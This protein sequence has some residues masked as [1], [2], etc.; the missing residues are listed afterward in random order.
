MKRLGI[1]RLIC[2]TGAMAGGDTPNWTR[3]VLRFVRRYRRKFPS[4][5]AD[6]DTQERIVRESGLDW[7]LV[8]PFRISGE[9]RKDRV[10]VAPG[11]RIGMF[12]SVRRK[13]LSEFIVQEV[14]RGRNHHR[15][16]YIVT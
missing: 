2:Q 9:R 16:V 14:T 6:R 8:K 13:N 12:T 11:L 5:N 7:T 3:G 15:A 4:V 1:E 10:Y